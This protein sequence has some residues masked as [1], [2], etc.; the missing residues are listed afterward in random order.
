MDFQF[1][2]GGQFGQLGG[3]GG[4][5]DPGLLMDVLLERFRETRRQHDRVKCPV[6][7]KVHKPIK[8]GQK[9]ICRHVSHNALE[10]F[11]PAPCPI[12]L[13][14]SCVACLCLH[15]ISRR[16]ILTFNSSGCRSTSQH[17]AS[18]WSC[19]LPIGFPTNRRQ[20]I[21]SLDNRRGGK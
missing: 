16:V 20:N 2:G 12:C 19:S 9:A 8:K 7:N 18:L 13:E 6:C 17:C 14:V 21:S 10:I 11:V 15:F 4:M 1:G 5:N 3:G